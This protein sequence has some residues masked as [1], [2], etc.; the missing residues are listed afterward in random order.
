MQDV[1]LPNVR[2]L[3]F[4]QLLLQKRT[5]AGLSLAEL[6]DLA[7]LPLS[8]LERL[9]Q[10]EEPVPSFDVCYKIAAAINSRQ[11]QGFLIQDLWQ[12]ASRDRALQLIS[13]TRNSMLRGEARIEIAAG[14]C[15]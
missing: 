15:R 7:C 9:E 10:D 4:S 1:T 11:M 8:L 2:S 5:S 3:S 13:M 6:A 12:A 14:L